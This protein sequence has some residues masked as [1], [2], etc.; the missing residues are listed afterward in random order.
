MTWDANRM[1]AYLAREIQLASWNIAT[2][3]KL[4]GARRFNGQHT[5]HSHPVLFAVMQGLTARDIC[6]IALAP[7]SEPPSESSWQWD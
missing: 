7:S 5:L 3:R 2:G 1:E 4:Y 6:D